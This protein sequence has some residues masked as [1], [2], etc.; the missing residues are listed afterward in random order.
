MYGSHHQ[1]P[2]K[3]GRNDKL[4]PYLVVREPSMR[5]IH[6]QPP[7]RL[8]CSIE[9]NTLSHLPSMMEQVPYL[10]LRQRQFRSTCSINII[11]D[12]AERLITSSNLVAGGH[13]GKAIRGP[14]TTLQSDRDLSTRTHSLKP[15]TTPR[16]SFRLLWNATHVQSLRRRRVEKPQ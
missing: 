10:Y 4:D 1:Q 11:S 7:S 3:Q 15:P 5:T 8:P 16:I 2:Q 12:G 14:P 6:G 13:S 9:P